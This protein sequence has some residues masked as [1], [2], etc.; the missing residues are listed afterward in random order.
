MTFHICFL[1]ETGGFSSHSSLG[2]CS[3]MKSLSG[4]IEQAV[5]ELSKSRRDKAL[6]LPFSCLFSGRK[7][8]Y[9][10]CAAA[11]AGPGAF[12]SEA[13]GTSRVSVK[14]G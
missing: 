5:T 8:V 10:V 2:S 1:S 3:K 9:A 6:G 7:G 14:Q 12:W 11:G 4:G 13:L